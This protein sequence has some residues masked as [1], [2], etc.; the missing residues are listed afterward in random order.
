MYN[1]R[2]CLGSLRKNLFDIDAEDGVDSKGV[3]LRS[4]INE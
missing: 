1:D 3:D 4:A 2:Y